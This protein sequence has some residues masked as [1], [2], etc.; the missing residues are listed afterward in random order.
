VDHLFGT[1]SAAVPLGPPYSRN[2]KHTEH[3]EH[4][5]KHNDKEHGQR[6]ER[7]G[8]DRD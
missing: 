4:R 1:P 3:E 6:Y 8:A 2:D 5:D 7:D